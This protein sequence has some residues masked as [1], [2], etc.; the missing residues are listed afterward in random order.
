MF[1]FFGFKSH[2]FIHENERYWTIKVGYHKGGETHQSARWNEANTHGDQN[3]QNKVMIIS[4][5]LVFLQEL[6]GTS[7]FIF[8]HPLSLIPR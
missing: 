5:H 7:F 3:D 4:I 1:L 2:T 8:Y 6:Q